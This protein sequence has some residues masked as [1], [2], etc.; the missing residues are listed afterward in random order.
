MN[1]WRALIGGVILVSAVA[2]F[3]IFM[4]MRLREEKNLISEDLKEFTAA[5]REF[6]DKHDR[7]PLAEDELKPFLEKKS[8]TCQRRAADLIV[9]WGASMAPGIPDGDK[10]AIAF[11]KTKTADKKNATLFQDGSVKFLTEP[12]L[13]AAEKAPPKGAKTKPK[14]E[15]KK[16]TG[17]MKSPS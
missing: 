12:E 15:P 17:P 14:D 6:E 10:R 13:N 4:M 3:V 5:Y 7:P 11:V 16:D 2:G 1:R 8:A 9:I